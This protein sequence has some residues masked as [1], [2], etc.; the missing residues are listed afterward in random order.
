MDRAPVRIIK[1]VKSRKNTGFFPS[2]KI[3]RPVAFESLLERDYIFLLEYD[4]CV[5]SYQ[6]QPITINYS[7]NNKDYRY[8]PDFLVKR[9]TGTQII[10]IKPKSKLLKLLSKEDGKRKLMAGHNYCFSNGYEYKIITEED[11]RSGSLLKNIKF[12][13]GFSKLTVPAS[14][15]MNIRNKLLEYR[16]IKIRE[17]ICCLGYGETQKYISYI[18][19][20]LYS[21]V[22]FTNLQKPINI[23][24]YI[25]A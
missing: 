8:T 18:Y 16:P 12:L 15:K 4:N 14:I 13:F 7:F 1:N 17:F 3:G 23:D 2:E 24:S 6:E 11:I 5:L 9:S 19:S 22:L 25:W 21:K 20:L 10:E